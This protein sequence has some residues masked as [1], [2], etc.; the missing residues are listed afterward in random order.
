MPP[1]RWA[2]E[3][4]ADGRRFAQALLVEVEGS[5]PLPAGAMMLVDEDGAV[6]GSITGGCV[7]SAVVQEAE[8]LLGGPPERRGAD[9]RDLRRAGRHGRADVRRHGP[10][11]PRRAARV[12]APRPSCEALSAHAARAARGDRDRAET[13]RQSPAAAWRSSAMR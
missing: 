10:H 12:R 6:E 9:L 1:R 5:A 13:A 11:L 8:A 3:W 4:L 2:I 7:E